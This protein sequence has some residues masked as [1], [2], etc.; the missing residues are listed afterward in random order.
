MIPARGRERQD[1]EQNAPWLKA[2]MP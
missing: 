1:Q 2:A